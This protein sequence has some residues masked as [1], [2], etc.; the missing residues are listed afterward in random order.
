[1]CPHVWE[2]TGYLALTGDVFDDVLF[3]DVFFP[4]RSGTQLSQFQEIFLRTLI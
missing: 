4:M 3:C 1:M 2:M